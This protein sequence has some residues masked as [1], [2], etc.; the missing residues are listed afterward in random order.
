MSAVK[1]A[2]KKVFGTFGKVVGLD[3]KTPEA[4]QS[5]VSVSTPNGET[6]EASLTTDSLKINKKIGKNRLKISKK[7]SG[8][9]LNV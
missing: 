5:A 7:S 6:Q 3:T 2:V 9:G 4:E 1:N 8:T